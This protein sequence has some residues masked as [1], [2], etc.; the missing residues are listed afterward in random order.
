MSMTTEMNGKYAM[1]AGYSKSE[2]QAK[3]LPAVLFRL[4]MGSFIGR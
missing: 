3:N 2:R 4:S 1:H